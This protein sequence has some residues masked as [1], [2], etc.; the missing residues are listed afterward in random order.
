MATGFGTPGANTALDALAAAYTW[1]GLH[2]GD[3]GASGTS[4][5]ATETTRKQV[6]WAAAA[7]ASVANSVA[8]TWTNIS[9]SEDAT[10]FTQKSASSAGNFG[11]SGAITA[12]PYTAG[13]TYSIAIGAL[14]LSATVAS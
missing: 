13:D 2:I 4:N 9:G 11:C 1:A 5:N 14:V 8:V 12:N 3:P 10:F 7:S 6:T